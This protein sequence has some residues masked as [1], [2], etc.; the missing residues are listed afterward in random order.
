MDSL[1]RRPDF[2][3]MGRGLWVV[4]KA[5]SYFCLA[6]ILN[7]LGRGRNVARGGWSG[8]RVEADVDEGIVRA[9]EILSDQKQRVAWEE[10]D[11]VPIRNY[12][13]W[14]TRRSLSG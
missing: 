4:G 13:V 5:G 6:I 2:C 14:G 7:V 8:I 1:E 12:G 3:L 9:R 10:K 11:R